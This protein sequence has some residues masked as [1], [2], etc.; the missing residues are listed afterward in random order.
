MSEQGNKSSFKLGLVF[1]VGV[2]CIL[3][4]F[5]WAAMPNFSGNHDNMV[6]NTC[7]NN[8][9]MIDAAANQFALEH[10]LTNGNHI[11]F[12]NDI[13]PYLG[14]AYRKI[15][16]CP[17]GG[18]YSLKQIGDVPTCSLGTNVSPTHSLQWRDSMQN[19]PQ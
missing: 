2:V 4:L 9:R 17:L 10:N 5:V 19:L 11:N 1:W 3:G 16:Q 12:P 6:A 13:T 8:I 7:I 18:V 15:P 14:R